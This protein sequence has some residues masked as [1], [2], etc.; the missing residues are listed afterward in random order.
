MLRL[1]TSEPYLPT[2]AP[3]PLMPQHGQG[4]AERCCGQAHDGGAFVGGFLLESVLGDPRAAR[5]REARLV[6]RRFAPDAC[7][8]W[9]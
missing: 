2:I 1:R 5:W 3:T 9:P 4:T 6:E 8:S 7:T